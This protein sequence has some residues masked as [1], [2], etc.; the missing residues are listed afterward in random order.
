MTNE[1]WIDVNVPSQAASAKRFIEIASKFFSPRQPRDGSIG[2]KSSLGNSDIETVSVYRNKENPTILFLPAP[3][4]AK[5]PVFNSTPFHDF[6]VGALEKSF[7][8][9]VRST[10]D[11]P[12]IALSA[13]DKPDNQQQLERLLA[14]VFYRI[15]EEE[16][17]GVS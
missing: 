4:R 11:E 1:A 10:G 2:F 17:K 15:S 3:L 16:K 6:F 5:Y 12:T 7:G 14:F 13:L 8:N 9:S